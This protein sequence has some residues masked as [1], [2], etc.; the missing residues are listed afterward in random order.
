MI[1]AICSII[2]LL[3]LWIVLRWYFSAWTTVVTLLLLCFGT[4]FFLM[5]VYSG[6]IQASILLALMV[7]VVWLT[8]RWDEKPGWALSVILGL[9]MGCM[10][11]IK[12]AGFAS[13]L[14]FLFWGVY[15]KDSFREKWKNFLG[16]A[17]MFLTVLV[18]FSGGVAM[19]MSLPQAFEG[20][21]FNDY[22]T[23]TKAFCFL[24]PY[25]YLVLFS[26]KNGWI[27]YT[28]LVLTAIPGFY[29][30]AE[31]NK[32]V[33]YS[34][35]LY[36]L[37]FILIFASAPNSTEP[38]NY[39]QARMTEIFAVLFIPIGYF[40]NWIT[41]GK[42]LRKTLSGIILAAFIALNLFQTWQYRN[43]ILNPWFTTPAYYSAVFL[44]THP[45]SADRQFLDF[46]NLDPG[47]Y[48]SNTKG[49]KVSTIAYYD[50]ENDPGGYGG[51]IGEQYHHTGK[52][53]FR[54]DSTLQFIPTYIL[55]LNKVPGKYPIGIRATIEILLPDAAAEENIGSLIISQ[56]HDGILHHYRSFIL[57]G[58]DY[59]P[60][61]WYEIHLDYMLTRPF[62]PGD[63]LICHLWYKGKRSL[64][65]DDLKIELFEPVDK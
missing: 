52:A 9:A 50:Y 14:L 12:S 45:S 19:R 41:E 25:L 39:G 20:S 63:E 38:N 61:K 42:W 24:A 53:A 48:L 62:D 35:F 5:A 28:P 26:A 49:F 1:V 40:V 64:W 15:N 65:A 7:L 6:A 34:V 11:F 32:P 31:R 27:V 51:H 44:K 21:L 55:P 58:S 3:G 43:D 23:G 10:V 47:A 30:L 36:S 29:I 54:I 4:N 60:G 56:R 17:D 8:M 16:H 57:H 18:L 22:V 46:Y 13:I 2:T 37:A 59:K 33:F